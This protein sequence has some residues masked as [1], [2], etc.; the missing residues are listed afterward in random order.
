MIVACGFL[1]AMSQSNSSGSTSQR[2]AIKNQIVRLG[3]NRRIKALVLTDGTKLKGFI[4]EVKSDSVVLVSGYRIVD[5]RV[6]AEDTSNTAREIRFDQISQIKPYRSVISAVVV[7]VVQ[8]GAVVLL[9]NRV[10]RSQAGFDIVKQGAVPVPDN[11]TY[12][13]VHRGR[14]PALRV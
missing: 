7:G 11:C 5:G 6:V 8:G 2:D 10:H 4:K 3:E 1:P 12:G 14:L 9:K 13:G